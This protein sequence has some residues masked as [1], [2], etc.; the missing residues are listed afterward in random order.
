MKKLFQNVGPNENSAN[1][2]SKIKV[3]GGRLCHSLDDIIW[4]NLPL[5]DHALVIVT[6]MSSETL[7]YG[8]ASPLPIMS[9]T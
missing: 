8:M 4:H 3:L 5:D 2:K 1:Y 7:C 6:K 9:L